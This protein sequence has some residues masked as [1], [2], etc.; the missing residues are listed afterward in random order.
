[1]V[2]KVR[3]E[4][5]RLESGGAVVDVSTRSAFWSLCRAEAAAA[6][7]LDHI[8]EAA[9]YFLNPPDNSTAEDYAFAT[10]MFS[11]ALDIVSAAHYP[12]EV[13]L[14]DFTMRFSRENATAIFQA[15]ASREN[16]Y[17]PY[18]EEEVLPRLEATAAAVLG[19]SVT[20][21]SQ[22]IPAI[23]LARL[24][25][26][27]LPQTRIV[28][29][30]QIFNRLVDRV[31]LLPELFEFVDFFI[32]NE[33][34]TALLRLLEYISG[35]TAIE[36]VPN[37]LYRD[38]V[39]GKPT[40][41][42]SRHREDVAQLPP[43][44]FSDLDLARYLAPRPVLPYQPVR[45]CY[46]SRCAFCNQFAIHVA[47]ARS[48][49]P[50]AV[51]QELRQLQTAYGAKHFTLVNESIHPKLLTDYAEAI[52]DAGLDL[53]W[54]AG[55][56]FEAELSRERLVL[57]KRSGCRKL[58]FG[59]ES[60][61]QEVLNAM[62]KGI[63]LGQARRILQDCSDLGLPVHLFVLLGFP[64]ETAAAL[65]E[66][67]RAI[68]ELAQIAPREAF[69]F[70]ISVFQLKPCTYVFEHPDR[71]NISS[72]REACEESGLEYLYSFE[73]GGG[74]ERKEDYGS[75]R[76]GLE[77]ALDEMQEGTWYPENIVHYL[78]MRHCF[79]RPEVDGAPR[80][81]GSLGTGELASR[82]LFT[83]RSALGF[84]TAARDDLL[85]GVVGDHKGVR[86]MNLVY[87]LV[88]DEM[89]ELADRS[90]WK[91]L[92]QAGG[93]FTRDELAMRICADPESGDAHEASRIANELITSRLVTPI[94]NLGE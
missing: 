45:G 9:A 12:T 14:H 15:T 8:E 24:V 74:T 2:A 43:P 31:L 82:E 65:A 55:A 71:F 36:D 85:D 49:A 17:L 5:M 37:L 42:R 33:G 56:R 88:F 48:K 60:G 80:S 25:R 51:A 44:D 39:T 34:E 16:P 92:Q 22:I 29:G 76:A 59:L 77:A 47:G 58:Y 61:S 66:S 28:V 84:C 57:L 23:T 68:L 1:M 4:R 75:E 18:F 70:Y 11:A 63:S 3:E 38:P 41:S 69:T 87:D 20:A 89:F 54:Y 73:V 21:M 50:G 30:G 62:R 46:W 32:L 78:T 35:D 72:I 6:L 90:G 52:L 83:V 67:K 64:T 40:R 93:R 19:L 86:R 7:V 27:R 13:S 10:R 91:A 53:E 94:R 26:R 79:H 81:R